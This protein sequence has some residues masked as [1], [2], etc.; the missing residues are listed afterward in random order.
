MCRW[1]HLPGSS[2]PF[3]STH[4]AC[5]PALESKSCLNLPSPVTLASLSSHHL[6]LPTLSTKN[7]TVREWWWCALRFLPTSWKT[8]DISLFH[9]GDSPWRSFFNAIIKL[10]R[11]DLNGHYRKTLHPY[12][13]SM[14][15][16]DPEFEHSKYLFLGLVRKI[17][18]VILLYQKLSFL[19]TTDLLI[20]FSH[21]YGV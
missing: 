1:W 6:F 3:T 12:W 10:W 16:S 9:E 14:T 18:S 2:G 4:T 15:I 13:K 11:I 7:K 20:A 5:V 17:F 19:N 8:E 21:G